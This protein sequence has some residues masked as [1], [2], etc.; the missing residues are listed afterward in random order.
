MGNIKKDNFIPMIAIPPGKTIRENMK[1]LGMD[2]EELSARLGITPKHMSNLIHGKT[3]L[4]YEI[5][6]KLED[7]IGVDAKFWLKL[8]IN[9]QLDKARLDDIRG[10]KEDKE[11]LSSIPYNVMRKYDWVPNVRDANSKINNL[12]E[13]FGVASLTLIKPS[14]EVAFRKQKIRGEISDYATLAWLRRAELTD[15]E[16]ISNEF[17]KGLLSNT[18]PK[19]QRLTIL[20]PDK[21]YPQIVKLCANCGIAVSLVEHLPKTAICGASIWKGNKVIIALSLRGKR[22]DIFWFT[23]FHEIAHLI[24]H[25]KRLR[26]HFE[27]ANETEEKEADEIA[28][29]ILIPKEKYNYFINNYAYK[30]KSDIIKFSTKINID[31]S[32]LVGRMMHDGLIGFNQFSELRTSFEIARAKR[33][34]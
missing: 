3:A 30:K 13:F 5:A 23:F 29:N 21:F 26:V 24:K 10:Y 12:R 17:D 7:V 1:Y 6:L 27:K 31:P 18:V 9:Y 22:A 2:Q 19:L 20:P 16:K 25:D 14:V 15:L 11:I 4:T 32:I 8:E 33:H 28:S 34:S